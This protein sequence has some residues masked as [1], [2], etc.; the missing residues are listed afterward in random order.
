MSD[1]EY[2]KDRFEQDCVTA[3]DS[4]S[5]EKIRSL[6][7]EQ[8][9]GE[10]AELPERQVVS[11]VVTPARG[12]G[13]QKTKKKHWIRNSIAV[14][15][16]LLLVVV[17][18]PKLIGPPDTSMTDDGYRTYESYGELK[19]LIDSLAESPGFFGWNK[20][21]EL[22]EYETADLAMEDSAPLSAGAGSSSANDASDTYV[23]VEGVDEADK[24][25]TDGKYIYHVTGEGD[26]YILAADRGKT[27][28]VAEISKFD[29]NGYF[30]QIYLAEDRLVAVG[31]L[32]E[33]EELK[34]AVTT[35]DIS[36]PE[37]PVELQQFLQSGYTVSSRLTGGILYLVTN[38]YVGGGDRYVPYVTQNGTYQKMPVGDICVFPNPESASYIVVSSVNVTSGKEMETVSKAILGSSSEIYCNTEHL[39]VA[40]RNY[41][42]TGNGYQ[43]T[44]RLLRVDLND[45]KIK[46]SV[47][48]KV[49]GSVYGQFG[50]DERDGYFR[51]AT[52]S[53]RNGRDVNNLYILDDSLNQVGSVTG[54]AR[55]EHIEAVRYVGDKAY[56][57]TYERT[58]PLF[59]LDLSDPEDPVIEGEV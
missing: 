10:P 31:T 2:I 7:E 22:V 52:T 26:I 11:P 42:D 16:C 21:E 38:D 58:D 41:E 33:D 5:E 37:N 27:R 29:E 4:L 18:V 8:N 30:S 3:P 34:A 54:F 56:V 45:G 9:A 57:I 44:T 35:Y 50:M 1:W 49:R 59:I 40:G 15:A 47:N 32:Y 24:I 46:F 51:I 53:V 39:Y 12:A 20:K 13:S 19:R 43:V 55:N 25:K 6:L 48:G 36:D 23:Q 17:S 28:K 14:A